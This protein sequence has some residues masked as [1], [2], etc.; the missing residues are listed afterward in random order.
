MLGY[1]IELH[2]QGK[3]ALVVGLGRVGQRKA[4]GLLAAGAYVIGVDPRI[5]RESAPRVIEIYSEPYRTDHL[6]GISLAVAAATHEINRQV[7]DD[8]R[9]QRIWVCSASDPAEGDFTVPAVWRDGLLT[10]AISTTGAS[11]ALAAAI[12]DRA[13]TAIGTSAPGLLN[14]LAELRPQVLAQ[15]TNPE[16]RRQVFTA[17]ADR[18]W[19]TL[20]D[21]KGPDAVRSELLLHLERAVRLSSS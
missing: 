6:S 15:V 5:S 9:R 12:R 16:L 19:L 13:A 21:Q 10:L 1:P 2:L 8:A 7:I 20:W 11:P 17:W 14:L 18:R 4:A 3:K